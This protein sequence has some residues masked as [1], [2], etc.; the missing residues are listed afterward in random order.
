MD[1]RPTQPTCGC[2]IL[3]CVYWVKEEGMWWYKWG[4][5][6]LKVILNTR[7]TIAFIYWLCCSKMEMDIFRSRPTL[8]KVAPHWW[9]TTP[10]KDKNAEFVD[11]SRNTYL[12][13]R[14]IQLNIGQAG[15][16]KVGKVYI[17]PVS[18]SLAFGYL[19]HNFGTSVRRPWFLFTRRYHI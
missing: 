15:M 6:N 14:R 11:T 5:L 3:K 19:T 10:G 7:M 12:L 13:M 16:E 8:G 18:R 17:Y 4:N 9:C 2:D 1:P